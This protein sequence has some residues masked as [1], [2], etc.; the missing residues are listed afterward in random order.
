V[1]ESKY[2]NSLDPWPL[3]KTFKT[4]IQIMFSKKSLFILIAFCFVF[5]YPRIADSWNLNNTIG[6]YTRPLK[7]YFIPLWFLLIFI[8]YRNLKK[9]KI[10][11][12]DLFFWTHFL[13]SFIPV[14]YINHPFVK[15]VIPLKT[16]HEKQ[17]NLLSNI[18]NRVY[19]YFLT[20]IV[21]YYLLAIK[22]SIN[23]TK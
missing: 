6:W 22:L 9:K 12:T 11:V 18:N 2:Y 13:L 10:M 17:G 7:T 23:S 1:G 14:F 21:L 8:T 4:S 20:Q 15:N 19:L 3:C 16:L 5:T